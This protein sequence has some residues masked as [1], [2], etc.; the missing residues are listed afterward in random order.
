MKHL[1]NTICKKFPLQIQLRRKSN[2]NHQSL[3]S[4]N[5]SK[6]TSGD[7][8]FEQ[9]LNCRGNEARQKRPIFLSIKLQTVLMSI[10]KKCETLR[11]GKSKE[12][13]K[14][15]TSTTRTKI[16][17]ISNRQPTSAK[18]ELPQTNGT[19]AAAFCKNE[20]CKREC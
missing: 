1:P 17:P 19:C 3:P 9:G 16:S 13:P 5:L 8:L 15:T 10:L 2:T 11:N 7:Q 20:E 14:Q 6:I 18:L 4:K 12:N